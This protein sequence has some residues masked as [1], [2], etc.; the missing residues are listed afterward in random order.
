MSLI[1]N[2]KEPSTLPD[3][4]IF[5]NEQLGVWRNNKNLSYAGDILG[6]LFALAVSDYFEDIAKYILDH[7]L[8]E[9]DPRTKLANKVLTGRSEDFETDVYPLQDIESISKTTRHEL[10]IVRHSLKLE[11]KNPL[12]GGNLEGYM[13][14]KVK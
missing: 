14:W 13:R 10:R 2:P 4:K 3:N 8:S 5:I 6:S 11:P 1:G 7:S 9:T 12:H